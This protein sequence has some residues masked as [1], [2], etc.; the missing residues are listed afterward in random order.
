M[1]RSISKA[2]ALID[3]T[4]PAVDARPAHPRLQPLARGRD[5]HRRP[6]AALL[7]GDAAAGRAP[8]AATPGTVLAAGAEGMDVQTG[9][10]VLRLISRAARRPPADGRRRYSPT[11]TAPGQGPRRMTGAGARPGTRGRE[12]RPR[13]A[14]G[15]RSRA[16]RHAGGRLRGLD[17]ERIAGPDRAQ[18]K[19]L[20]FGALR[21]HHRHRELLELLLDR[22][23]PAGEKLLEAL[24]SVGPV[25]AARRAPA[26]LRRGVRHGRGGALARA[27]RGPRAW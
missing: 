7:A 9:A 12:P 15:R 22:P 23:L 13:R 17:L 21:W 19:A 2:E 24:L 25:P 18:V 10:G 26:R 8:A 20:A 5:A 3:W 6:A 11:A 4:E 16:R 27:R 1:R 14:R